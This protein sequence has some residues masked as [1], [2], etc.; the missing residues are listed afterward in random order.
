MSETIF[1]QEA[2][3][4]IW[5]SKDG[6]QVKPPEDIE[7]LLNASES[8]EAAIERYKMERAISKR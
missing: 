6:K 3:R 2:L 4:D 8:F 5:K 7:A 1:E